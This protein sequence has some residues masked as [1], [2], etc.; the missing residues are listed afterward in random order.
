MKSGIIDGI[1][2]IEAGSGTRINCLNFLPYGVLTT[3]SP[4]SL[5]GRLPRSDHVFGDRRLGYVND[6]LEQFTVYSWGSPRGI[7]NVH[8]PDEFSNL[9]FSTW[10]S[11]ATAL[12][13]P[14]SHGILNPKL[15]PSYHPRPQ[16]RAPVPSSPR[17]AAGKSNL[18][19]THGPHTALD[20]IPIGRRAVS[21]NSVFPMIRARRRHAAHCD[22]LRNRKNRAKPA[23]LHPITGRLTNLLRL[24]PVIYPS[25]RT[26]RPW[27]PCIPHVTVEFSVEI[28]P[29]PLYLLIGRLKQ[30]PIGS[31]GDAAPIRATVP[32][33]FSG[34]RAAW[35]LFGFCRIVSTIG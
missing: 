32:A 26:Q 22:H 29:I 28:R 21:F 11:W 7:G 14:W 9:S 35:R 17:T 5:R 3:H 30:I 31:P 10:S 12:P 23:F 1:Y 33:D 34:R 13:A 8:F 2:S 27:F 15:D 19:A 24:T 6:Q 25:N 4:P 16:L 20:R 18:P